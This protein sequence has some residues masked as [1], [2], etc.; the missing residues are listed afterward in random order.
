MGKRQGTKI[1]TASV[2]VCFVIVRVPPQGAAGLRRVVD[3]GK[4]GDRGLVDPGVGGGG[5]HEPL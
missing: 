5:K 3:G 1:A 4:G 2:R